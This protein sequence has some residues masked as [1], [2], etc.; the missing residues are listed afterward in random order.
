VG[1]FYRIAILILQRHEEVAAMRWSEIAPDLSVWTMLGART[2]NGK[3]HDVDLSQAAQA[4]L[5]ALSEAQS[6]DKDDPYSQ[7]CKREACDFVFSTRGKTSISGFSRAKA[8]LDAAITK[9]RAKAAATGGVEPTPLVPWRLHDL[10]R[11]G[12]STLAAGLRHHRHRQASRPSTGARISPRSGC[13]PSTRGPST[14]WPAATDGASNRSDATIWCLL[15]SGWPI[16]L[17]YSRATTTFRQSGKSLARVATAFAPS[18]AAARLD[19]TPRPAGQCA[20]LVCSSAFDAVIRNDYQP[21]RE[22]TSA[23][24]VS[25]RDNRIN[26]ITSIGVRHKRTTFFA[27]LQSQLSRLS[28]IPVAELSKD[29]CL[30]ASGDIQLL[31]LLVSEIREPPLDL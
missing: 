3:L 7:G 19:R 27:P 8:A 6:K 1:P 12:A 9:A 22:V 31:T 21:I 24:L 15:L 13:V 30:F 23:A 29:R 5:R 25:G 28:A 4:L 2:K 17:V 18:D 20:V 10:Q 14:C 26:C 11:T 16:R